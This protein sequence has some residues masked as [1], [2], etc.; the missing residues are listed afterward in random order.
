MHS[1]CPQSTFLWSTHTEIK[2]SEQNIKEKGEVERLGYNLRLKI[3]PSLVH[4][5]LAFSLHPSCSMIGEILP[6]P[7]AYLLPT[8]STQGH[9]TVGGGSNNSG[10]FFHPASKVQLAATFSC[11][12]ARVSLRWKCG[13]GPDLNLV[14]KRMAKVKRLMLAGWFRVL[15][16]VGG[17]WYWCRLGQLEG[18][19]AVMDS[20]A[21]G[22]VALA[23]TPTASLTWL[24]SDMTSGR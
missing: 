11:C 4:S 14:A 21:Q 22:Y 24:L 6:L 2:L 1:V 13:Q 12:S 10:H 17:D 3:A 7:T 23:P 16:L 19:R 9:L 20:S 5:P 8:N 18:R 15:R